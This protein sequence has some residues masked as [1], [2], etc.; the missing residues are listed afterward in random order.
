[1]QGW[2]KEAEDGISVPFYPFAG[3]VKIGFT[4]AFRHLSAATEYL[5]ALVE[6]LIGGGD[7]GFFAVFLMQTHSQ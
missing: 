4:H 3:F 1:M 5:P 7:T 6:T 2:L